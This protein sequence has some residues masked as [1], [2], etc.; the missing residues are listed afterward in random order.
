MRHLR[1]LGPTLA[2]VG[3]LGMVTGAAFAAPI[4]TQTPFAP[5]EQAVGDACGANQQRAGVYVYNEPD[6][7][8]DCSYFQIDS[9][10][11]DR[12]SVGNDMARSIRIV[13][14]NLTTVLWYDVGFRGGGT[15]FTGPV[16]IR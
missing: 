13:G 12:W 14:D 9:L 10:S 15:L 2:A 8:G 11:P 4:P 3:L 16:A 7:H 6:F 5:S 1:T